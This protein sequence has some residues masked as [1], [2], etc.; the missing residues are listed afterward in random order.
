M[1]KLRG[2]S[3]DVKAA[4]RFEV[5]AAR[6]L[7]ADTPFLD[8]L[9]SEGVDYTNCLTVYPAHTVTG[10][11]PKTHG[12]LSNFVPNLESNASPYATASARPK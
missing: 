10:A 12:M 3:H 4:S 9:R 5:K 8:S 7:E 2:S 11:P 1:N 6:L